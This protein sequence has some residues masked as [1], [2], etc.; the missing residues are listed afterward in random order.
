[1]QLSFVWVIKNSLNLAVSLRMVSIE[2]FSF[3][4]SFYIKHWYLLISSFVE[5]M[6]WFMESI[7][8]WYYFVAWSKA[9]FSLFLSSSS[10]SYSSFSRFIW[11]SSSFRLFSQS[12]FMDWS[13]FF[14]VWICVLYS[15]LVLSRLPTCD[16]H[17]CR[18]MS[19][20]LLLAYKFYFCYYN[21]VSF[22]CISSLSFLWSSSSW[23]REL[24]VYCVCIKMCFTCFSRPRLLAHCSPSPFNDRFGLRLCNG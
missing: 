17:S 23:L 4:L 6:L 21:S 5:L 12:S 16:L 9:S 1:M 3:S 14:I 18:S 19:I 11:C 2:N 8:I 22:H 15:F 24:I 20:F 13:S 10:L 7:F